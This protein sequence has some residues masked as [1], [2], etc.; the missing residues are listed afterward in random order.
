[1]SSRLDTR[2]LDDDLRAVLAREEV[3]ERRVTANDRAT[4]Y[5]MRLLPYRALSRAVEGVLVTFTN[6]TSVVASEEHQRMLTA[7][8]SHRIKNTLA[9]IASIASQTGARAGSMEA[10][11]ETFLGRLQGLASTHQLLSEGDW[12][13]VGLHGLIQRE[14]A[15][16]AKVDGRRLEVSGPPIALKPRAAIAFGMVL[17]EL[18]TNSVKYGALSVPEGRLQV[19]WDTPRRSKPQ[20]LELHWMESGGPAPSAPVKRGFGLEFIGR[21]MQFELDGAAKIAFEQT[22]LQCTIGVPL[23]PDVVASAQARTGSGS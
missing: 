10:F 6:I 1:V 23:G 20:R 3:V 19:S 8:L 11:L 16:Y 5:L 17:H 7:E 14:L 4:H 18:A 12:A 9:V 15:P 21:A 22:G 2:G 13:D